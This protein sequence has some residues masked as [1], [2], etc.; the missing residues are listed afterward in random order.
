MALS[1]STAPVSFRRSSVA[2]QRVSARAAPVAKAGRAQLRVVAAEGH[3][4]VLIGLAADSGC[5]K[6][7]FMRRTCP[8]ARRAAVADEEHHPG[9]AWGLELLAGRPA[10]AAPYAPRP[11]ARSQA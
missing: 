1:M 2:G 9:Y 8:D 10:A 3:K 5:G 4:T 6:S 7:T 11:S